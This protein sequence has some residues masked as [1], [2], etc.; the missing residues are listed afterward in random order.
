[1]KL[2]TRLWIRT[3]TSGD[4]PIAMAHQLVVRYDGILADERRQAV[5][6]LDCRPERRTL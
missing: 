5:E 1:V 2:L 4:V 6:K 3:A